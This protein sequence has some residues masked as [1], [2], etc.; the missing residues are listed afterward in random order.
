MVIQGIEDSPAR[1]VCSFNQIFSIAPFLSPVLYSHLFF[2]STLLLSTGSK[3]LPGVPGH[4]GTHGPPGEPSKEKGYLGDPGAQGLPG[5]KGMPG[6]TG[7]RGISGFEGM[8]GKKVSRA[9]LQEVSGL[10]CYSYHYIIV[11]RLFHSH[12]HEAVIRISQFFCNYMV[13]VLFPGN[14]RKL[15]CLWCIRRRWN[16]GSPRYKPQRD[17]I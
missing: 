4:E 3:G 13:I 6:L 10:L 8:P 17:E 16:K 7:V 14:K 11:L 5:F 15:W 2:P 12:C 1:E 9:N